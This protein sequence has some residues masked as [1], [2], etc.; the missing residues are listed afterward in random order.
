MPFSSFQ[1][2]TP[3]LV[4]FNAVFNASVN[5]TLAAIERNCTNATVEALNCIDLQFNST[6]SAFAEL[7]TN[8]TN[9]KTGPA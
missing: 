4:A 5:W 8:Y 1:Q 3:K 6:Q 7:Q 9:C 2:F